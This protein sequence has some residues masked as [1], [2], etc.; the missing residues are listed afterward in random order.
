V[1]DRRSLR[2]VATFRAKSQPRQF[3]EQLMMLGHYYNEALLIPEN[4]MSGGAVSALIEQGYRRVFRHVKTNRIRGQMDNMIGWIT[5]NQ[6]K[7]EAI[8]H[9]Q[10]QLLFAYNSETSFEIRDED[11]YHEM[12]NYIVND[13]GKFTN[14]DGSDH[15]DTVM[16][17]AIAVAGTI[18]ETP[19]MAFDAL[20]D[21]ATQQARRL[22]TTNSAT[23]DV[24]EGM[25]VVAGSQG[26]SAVVSGGDVR[27]DAGRQLWT[28]PRDMSWAEADPLD[29]LYGQGEE[30]S[31]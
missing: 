30:W 28:P 14:G 1:L 10:E 9:L 26:E 6:T 21:A 20:T 4:N 12:K 15:D 22:Q 5:N 11:T 25:K 27:E 23:E 7:A 31:W 19:Q 16:A 2:Q 13:Q 29:D 17:L 18:L 24:R 8:Q 3:A